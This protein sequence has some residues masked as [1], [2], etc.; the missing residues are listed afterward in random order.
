MSMNSPNKPARSWAG[1]G[2]A[3]TDTRLWRAGGGGVLCTS[4][5]VPAPPWDRIAHTGRGP[6]PSAPGIEMGETTNSSE[7]ETG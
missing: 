2:P 7:G 1:C 5:H 6:P 4:R 3:M